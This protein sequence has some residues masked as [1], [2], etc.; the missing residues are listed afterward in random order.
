MIVRLARR[1]R[2][3][4]A[5]LDSWWREHRPAAPTLFTD[6]LDQAVSLLEV[7]PEMGPTYQTRG[8]IVLRRLMLPKTR[9]HVYY[10]HNPGTALVVVL[11]I[12]SAQRGRAPK[13]H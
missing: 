4:A 9:Y 10:V 5:A 11:S 6:E 3:E 12:W 1:A 13:L 8:E 7:I 2:R